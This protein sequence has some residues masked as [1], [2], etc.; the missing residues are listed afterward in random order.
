MKFT[1]FTRNDDFSKDLGE[2]LKQTVSARPGWVY[3]ESDPCLVICVGGDGTLLRAIHKYENQLDHT[4]FTAIH[5]G[6]LG[7]FTDYTKNDIDTFL[8]D[9][10][11]KEP[12]IESYPLIEAVLDD[13]TEYRALNEIRIGSF[14]STVYYD[15]FI[16]GEFFESISSCGLCVSTQAGSTGANRALHGAVVENGLNVLEMTQIMPV[17]HVNHHSLM[18]PYIMHRDRKITLKGKSI[19]DSILCHDHLVTDRLK[20]VSSIEI[21]LCEKSVRFARYRS[22]SYLKRL[23]NLF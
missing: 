15:V 5:T 14:A 1:V 22:Y 10:L 18:S 8:T 13:G 12:R 9:L 4:L 21:R 11:T 16:D 19:E 7:F 17:D 2:H 23:R 3:D 20:G 6:T